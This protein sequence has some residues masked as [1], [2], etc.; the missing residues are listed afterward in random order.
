MSKAKVSKP[1]PLIELAMRRALDEVAGRLN[2]ESTLDHHAF[3][4]DPWGPCTRC[5]HP[6]H[7][8]IHQV[9]E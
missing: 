9:E 7:H 6:A 5:E 8:A 4:G 3:Q 2:A 1:N